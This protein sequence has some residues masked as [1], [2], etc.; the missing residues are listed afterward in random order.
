M[1]PASV[2]L[3]ASA[4]LLLAPLAAADGAS[5]D[6]AFLRLASA[7]QE[8]YDGGLDISRLPLPEELYAGPVTVCVWFEPGFSV[9][10]VV[11]DLNHYLILVPVPGIDPGVASGRSSAGTY[12]IQASFSGADCSG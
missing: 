11:V 3:N 5:Q 7:V 2:L 6:A 8:S 1:N 10:S 9:Q 4:V 12:F